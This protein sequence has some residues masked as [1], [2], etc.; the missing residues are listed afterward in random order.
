MT[1]KEIRDRIIYQILLERLKQN[2]KWGEQNH[3]SVDPVLTDRPGGC[4]PERMCENYDLPSENY[5]KNACNIATKNGKLTYAHIAVE[6]MC[7]VVSAPDDDARREELI[8]LGVVVM[9]WI[10][11]IDRRMNAKIS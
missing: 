11:C 1:E 9:Q 2:E 7:E 10:E 4:T 6:E 5:A 3:P 8:Q